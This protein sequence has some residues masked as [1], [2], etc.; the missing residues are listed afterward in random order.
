METV[1]KHLDSALE[2]IAQEKKELTARLR[3]LTAQEEAVNAARDV[4]QSNGNAARAE[5]K[6]DGSRTMDFVILQLR[7]N[8]TL[9]SEKL[10]RLADAA[11]I[12]Y[13]DGRTWNALLMSLASNGRAENLGNGVWRKKLKHLRKIGIGN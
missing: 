10:S 5:A 1:R 11:G 4:T 12:E 3:A 7:S 9:T 2:A 8:E 6:S 13:K